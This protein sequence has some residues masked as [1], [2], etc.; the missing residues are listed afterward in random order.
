MTE[1]MQD[2][3]YKCDIIIMV[4]VRD[5]VASRNFCQSCAASYVGKIP[6]E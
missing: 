1:Y 5:Y 3:C 6:N 2:S 4:P